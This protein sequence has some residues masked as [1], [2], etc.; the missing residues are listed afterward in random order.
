M[1]TGVN[2]TGLRPYILLYGVSNHL[3]IWSLD[4][5]SGRLSF[6]SVQ[7]HLPRGQSAAVWRPVPWLIPS[8]VLRSR[9]TTL[10][11]LGGIG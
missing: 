6:Y 2:S 10:S 4:Q 5:E 7:V 3:S 1:S 8:R 11:S 9:L